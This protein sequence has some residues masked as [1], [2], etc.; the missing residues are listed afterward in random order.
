MTYIIAY[1]KTMTV[2]KKH[3]WNTNRNTRFSFKKNFWNCRL[4]NFVWAL[5]SGHQCVNS[6]WRHMVTEIWV[7][8]GSGNDLLPDS[9]K[10]LPEPMLT[11]H[12]WGPVTFTTGQFYEMP[13]PSITESRLKITYLKFH[14]DFP[15]ANELII[16]YSSSVPWL[17]PSIAELMS[18]QACDLKWGGVE[19]GEASR[20]N[21][22]VSAGRSWI[23]YG[24]VKF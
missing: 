1:V 20:R 23:G 18:A 9:T 5:L 7:K 8:I 3:Q 15:G 11:D 16:G 2:R 13:Q 19:Q 6:I 12:H 21:G 10:P 17:Q 4:R 24:G 22:L 14:S